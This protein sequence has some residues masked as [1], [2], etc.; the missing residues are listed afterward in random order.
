MVLQRL[1]PKEE[2]NSEHGV[3]VVSEYA[4]KIIL[5]IGKQSVVIYEST[6]CRFMKKP[7]QYAPPCGPGRMKAVQRNVIGT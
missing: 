2:K 5:A 3:E 4:I 7:S 6:A 1:A